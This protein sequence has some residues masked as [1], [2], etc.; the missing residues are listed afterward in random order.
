MADQLIYWRGHIFSNFTEP[1][2]STGCQ[3]R[4]CILFLKFIAESAPSA[5]DGLAITVAGK[6]RKVVD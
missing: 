3:P 2:P 1:P 5:R 4:A 6:K